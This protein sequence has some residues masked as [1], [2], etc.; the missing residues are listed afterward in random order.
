MR[1]AFALARRGCRATMS[2]PNVGA[3]LVHEGTIIGEGWHAQYGGPHAEV[4][5]VNS[6]KTS[7][8]S[9]IKAATLYVSLEPCCIHSKTPACTDLIIREKIPRVVYAS[10][11]PNLEVHGK[12]KG[13]LE[14]KGVEVISEVLRDE[15]DTAIR[16]FMAHLEKRPFVVLKWAQS[17]DGYIGKRGM[18]IKLSDKYTDMLSHKWRSESDGI[19]V[20][21]NTVMSD[22]P[23]LTTR[24]YPGDNPKRIIVTRAEETLQDS[25]LLNDG[26]PSMIVSPP[27]DT[28]EVTELL[29]DLYDIGIRYLLVEGGPST[30]RMFVE[31]GLWDEAR[32]IRCPLILGK[33]IR[34]AKLS[35]VLS[36]QQ[37]ISAD[38]IDYMTPTD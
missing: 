36:R 2:N 30:H 20:G 29:H 5:C 8:M 18:E 19:M 6:V 22:D 34:A 37:W 1:R 11:D 23:S 9:L 17:K 38:V 13:I 14:S 31:A 10:T 35:G 25:A 3:V 27:A 15:G 28:S 33:G 21:H 12:S 24:H 16:P 32:I 7:H 4:N 26:Q